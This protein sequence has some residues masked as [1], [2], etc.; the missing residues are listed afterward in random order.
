MFLDVDGTLLEF[1][2]QPHLVGV[3]EGLLETM[4]R[5]GD[6]LHG[7]LALV[8]GRPLAQ[9]DRLFAPL[10]LPA[11]GLHG[12]ELRGAPA[13]TLVAADALDAFKHEA[14]ALAARHP[15]AMVED[16]GNGVALHWRNAPHAGDALNAFART[17][18]ASLPDYRLQPGDR[19]IEIVPAN[20]DK[21][22]AVRAL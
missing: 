20:V 1:A 12:Q 3:P 11:A 7:A 6:R 5:V 14:R 10:R 4:Q 9:I 17:R 22:R 8:S 15:G 18:L 2:P 21:G 13:A 19:V 16:K